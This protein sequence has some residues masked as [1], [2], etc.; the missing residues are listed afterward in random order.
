MKAYWALVRANVLMMFR[1][2]DILFW[3]LA[4]PVIFMVLMG[5]V[6]GHTNFRATV[7]LTGGSGPARAIVYPVLRHTPGVKL[8]T[9]Q[10]LAAL[11]QGKVNLVV[12]VSGHHVVLTGDQSSTS[13][14]VAALVAGELAAANLRATGQAPQVVV[15]VH[16]LTGQGQTYMDFLVPGILGMALMNGGIFSGISLVVLRRQGV[17]RRIRGTPTSTLTFIAA[18]MTAQFVIVFG[19]AAVILGIA[20]AAYKFHPSGSLVELVPL[21]VA[22]A[23]AFMSIG[24]FVAG[25]SNTMEVASALT[26]VLTLPMMFLA[27]VFFPVSQLPHAMQAVANVMPLRFLTRGLRGVAIHHASWSALMPEILGL[28]VTTVIGSALATRFFR[29]EV[30]RD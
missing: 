23:L 3:N 26:N 13:Q 7:G 16:H 14:S 28:L 15:A 12:D 22:G 4:F 2:R 1:A 30:P 5:A 25:V 9:V 20:S 8:E 27:G 6:F 10:G 18:R 24:F 21:L 19:Q 11:R 29:W 17:L